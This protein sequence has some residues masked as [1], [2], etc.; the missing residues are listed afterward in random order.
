[1]AE[2]TGALRLALEDAQAANRAK[3]DFLA[4]MSHEIRTPINGVLGMGQLLGQ[5]ELNSEQ[6]EY[7]KCCSRRVI[8]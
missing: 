3:S 2:R 5:T 1:V 4:N 6:R 8:C 7:I